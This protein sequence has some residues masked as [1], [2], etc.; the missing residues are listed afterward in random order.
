MIELIQFPFSP[1]CIVIR[2][3]LE[4]AGVRFKTTN[5]PPSDRSL[6]WRLTKQRY[7]A[8]P[9]IRDGSTVVY[10][11]EADSQVIAKYLDDKFTLSLFPA[12]WE[13][14]QF[15]LWRYF[16]NEVEA[17]GFK[18]NDIYFQEFLPQSEQLS[19]IRH[20]ERK[21]GR[22]CLDQWRGNAQPLKEELAHLL[23]PCE[24]MLVDKP[25][26]LGEMPLFVDFDLYGMLGN[27][28][29]S[30]HH[31]W[32]ASCKNLPAWYQRMEKLPPRNIQKPASA[33][34]AKGRS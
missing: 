13:G 10:E 25:F 6:I 2:R 22:G 7:Y 8:V 14:V 19:F 5:I 1:Y 29:Y 30:G 33:P 21:F 34:P 18:L 24:T 17:V 32:P 16:E 9:V 27:Y 26:L 12:S 28:L 3:L 20:K 15:L 23:A 31:Q 11:S 4:Y